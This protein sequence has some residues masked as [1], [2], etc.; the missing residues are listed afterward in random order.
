MEALLIR[1]R[2]RL[3]QGQMN[4]G[5]ILNKEE[6]EKKRVKRVFSY[7]WVHGLQLDH[8]CI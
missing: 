8:G 5:E 6:E 2:N 7:S 3:W 1:L 4:I